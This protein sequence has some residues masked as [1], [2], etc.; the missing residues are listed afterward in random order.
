[1]KRTTSGSNLSPGASRWCFSGCCASS[2]RNS[3]PGQGRH[4]G[5]DAG[6][7]AHVRGGVHRAVD[8]PPV[9]HRPEVGVGQVHQLHRR[10]FQ[11][12]NGHLYLEQVSPA[13]S[14]TSGSAR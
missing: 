9:V 5:G 3:Y 1:M 7:H 8:Q 4:V 2:P 6:A 10:A 12:G 13:Y 14:F 11:V